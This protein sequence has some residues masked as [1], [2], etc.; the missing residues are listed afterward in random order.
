MGFESIASYCVPLWALIVDCIVGDPRSKFHPVVL[1]GHSITYFEN[2]FY[3]R[4]DENRTKLF[5]GFLT[6]IFVLLTVLL[7]S[8]VFLGILSLWQPW[9]YIIG[10]TI[11]LYISITPRSLAE[12]GWE[13]GKLL[14]HKQLKWAR[15]KVGWIV[16]R[17]TEDL[18]E[19][20]ITRATVET[21]AE[22]TVD[23]IV[24]PLFFFALFGPLGAIFY[25]TCNTMDSMLGYK[26]QKYMHFGRVAAKWDDVVN[27]IPARLTLVFI[28]L[29]SYVLGF[30]WRRAIAVTIRDAK[31]HPSPNGGFAEAPVAGALK[32]RLGGYNSY[33]G[34]RSLRAYMGD[35]IIPLQGHHI[36]KTIK[37]MYVATFLAVVITM[38]V[39]GLIYGSNYIG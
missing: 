28:V 1:I 35:P 36:Y 11:L 23:G 31:K 34:V 30:D 7:V 33:G 21:I 15:Y 19:S 32:V 18:N 24:A 3:A 27:Y 38:I 14:R 39:H 25:R 29:S 10:S 5:Y 20:E 13:I 4:A 2:I 37:I 22:N 26:N 9:G 8:W 16:G 17:D 6:V 12:A